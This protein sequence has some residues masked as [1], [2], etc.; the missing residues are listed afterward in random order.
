MHLGILK[1][2]SN[3]EKSGHKVDFMDLSAVKNYLDVVR[4]Y[5][6]GDVDVYGI[7]AST[8]QVPY[9]VEIC[10][11]SSQLDLTVKLF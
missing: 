3:L 8:P 9:A 11:S 7:T 5:A 10:S 6:A 4:D 1:V 2:A